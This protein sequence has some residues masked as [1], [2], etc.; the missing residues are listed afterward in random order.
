MTN[1]SLSAVTLHSQN[2]ERLAAFYRDA[3]G[4]PLA[5]HAHGTLHDHYEGSLAGIHFAVWKAAAAVGGPVVPVFRVMEIERE[6]ERLTRMGVPLMHKLLDI[7]E[8]KRVVTFCDPDQNGFR[9][10]QI[11]QA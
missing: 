11:D 9:L 7:G 8:G 3:V 5:V 2:P 10:I 1:S 6:L 4:I